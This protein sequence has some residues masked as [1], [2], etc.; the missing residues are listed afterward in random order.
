MNKRLFLNGLVGILVSIAIAIGGCTPKRQTTSIKEPEPAAEEATK[1]E[2]ISVVGD[3]DAVLVET[4][5]PVKYTAFKLTDPPRIIIDMPGVDVSTVESPIEI[6]N[7]YI[8]EIRSSTYGDEDK[9][10]GRIEIGLRQGILHRVKSGENSILVDLR[11]DVYISAMSGEEAVPEE[12]APQTADEVNTIIEKTEEDVAV[13]TTV[14]ATE[15]VEEPLQEDATNITDVRIDSEDGEVVIT[16][17]GDGEIGNFNAFGLDDPTRVVLD[18]WG[19][20]ATF[21]E[22]EFQVGSDVIEQ[23]RVG[24]HP[25][26]VRMVFDSPQPVVPS[27]MVDKEDGMLAVRFRK[28]EGGEDTAPVSGLKDEPGQAESTENAPVEATATVGTE[29][30]E[31]KDIRFK[32]LPGTARLVIEGTGKPEFRITEAKMGKNLIVD[33]PSAYIPEDL[34][35]TL[36]ATELKTP[37]ISISSYQASTR[38]E[39]G[40]IFIRLT[41]RTPYNVGEGDGFIYIDFPVLVAEKAREERPAKRDATPAKAREK[42]IVVEAYKTRKVNINM[43]DAQVVDVLRLLAEISDLNIVVSED[44]RGTITLK[45]KNV[46]WQQAFELVLRTK[47]LDSIREGNVIRVA[48]RDKIRQEKEEEM[49]TRAAQKKLEE[50]VTE[51]IRVNYDNASSVAP[52]VQSLLSDRGSVTVHETTNTLIVRDIK[53]VLREV[54]EHVRKVDIPIPQVLIETRIV[55]AES[56]FARDLGIQWGVDVR[57]SNADFHYNLFGSTSELG[58][59]APYPSQQTATFAGGGVTSQDKGSGFTADVGVTNY[60]V[61]LPAA[62]TAGTLGALGFIVGK[63][64]GTPLILDLRIS[65]GEKQGLVKTISRPRIVT[66]NNKEAKIEQGESVPFE[67]T[68]AAGTQTTFV[69]A[70]LSLTVKPQVTPDGSILMDIKASR[71]AIGTYRTAT[72]KPSISKKEASTTV[73]V[74]DGETTVIGG[75]IVS[76]MSRS[77]Q[78][79]P[80]LKDLPVLGWLFKGKSVTDS[81]KEL[82]IFITPT[83]LKKGEIQ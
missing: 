50:L 80:F 34:R 15:G 43:V 65:A 57:D 70:S 5:G 71:N 40:R 69:D 48:P 27:Y 25:D 23:M 78:G 12:E 75:I 77:E 72:G 64:K 41:G 42:P 24:V 62:G 39:L 31:I 76:D 22:K 60:A 29:R 14:V 61:N 46:P 28:A 6:N 51:F 19:V 9:R 10:I 82:L 17:V 36:D 83:I 53:S 47:G 7:N 59:A 1:V 66:L 67:T 54:K 13:E 45:L 33:L 74:K 8:T 55:E 30:V 63:H 35:V 2:L 4:D 56:S 52:Q 3:G 79:V 44:V 21:A 18:V 49:R 38:P 68:S 11:R 32:K 81:Q 58:S 73:L 37:V 16:L 20:G 26:K